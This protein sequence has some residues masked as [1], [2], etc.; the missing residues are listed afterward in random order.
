MTEH[1]NPVFVPGL[2]IGLSAIFP[3][4]LGLKRRSACR[5]MNRKGQAAP[6]RRSI[7]RAVETGGTPAQG[8]K[9]ASDEKFQW[10]EAVLKHTGT[11]EGTYRKVDTKTMEMTDTHRS[12]LEVGIHEDKYAERNTYTWDDGRVIQYIFTGYLDGNLVQIN[13]ERVLGTCFVVSDDLL[14]FY[15]NIRNSP[16]DIVDTVRLL[17]SKTRARTWQVRMNDDVVELVHVEEEKISS[18]DVYFDIVGN[19]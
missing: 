3:S 19:A 11:W 1:V 4:S 5:T 15:G 9:S 7:I 8:T 16:S 12:V 13:S 6:S 10:P 2:Q 18:K 17:T 14:V